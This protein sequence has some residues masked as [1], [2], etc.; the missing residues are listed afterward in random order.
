ML[1]SI[2]LFNQYR[3]IHRSFSPQPPDYYMIRWSIS[4]HSG[5]IIP[6][7][8]FSGVNGTVLCHTPV[9][10]YIAC[11]RAGAGVF[12]TISPIDFTPKGPDG[13]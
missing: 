6:I 8:I 10:L 2:S 7:R 1:L 4:F 5:S 3:L 11:A 13:S 12:I 9:A